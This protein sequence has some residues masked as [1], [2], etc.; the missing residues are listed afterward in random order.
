MKTTYEHYG[1][2]CITRE[3]IICEENVIIIITKYIGEDIPDQDTNVEVE[4]FKSEKD[5]R[6]KYYELCKEKNPKNKL[7]GDL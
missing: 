1:S 4:Q 5:A 7:R 2:Y 3:T 6:R